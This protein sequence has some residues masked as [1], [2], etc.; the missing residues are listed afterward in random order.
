MGIESGNTMGGLRPEPGLD[1]SMLRRTVPMA[2]EP[3]RDPRAVREYVTQIH[4]RLAMAERFL[5]MVYP[6]SD[7]MAEGNG[8]GLCGRLE[9]AVARTERLAATLERLA[10]DMGGPF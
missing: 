6:L 7:A 5:G 2:Y 9:D 4:D 10:V 1:E 3:A 8:A